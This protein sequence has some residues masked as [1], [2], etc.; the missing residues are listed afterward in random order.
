M[1]PAIDDFT[2]VFAEFME[3]GQNE[4]LADYCD[5]GTNLEFF[6]IY[7]NGYYRSTIDTLVSNYPAVL[8]LVGDDYFRSL[9]NHYVTEFPPC[10][11]SLVGY[12]HEFASFLAEHDVSQQLPYLSDIAR[13]DRAWL[14]VY[15][16]AENAPITVD[17]ISTLMGRGDDIAVQQLVLRA[18]TD[19]VSLDYVVTPVWQKLKETGRLNTAIEVIKKPEYVLVWRQHSEV[20][21]RPLPSVEFKFLSGLNTGLNLGEAAEIAVLDDADINLS[22]FFSNLITA[23]VLATPQNLVGEN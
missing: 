3:S 18:A 6:N 14:N 21:I 4:K 1:L 9:A 13:L 16:A 22:E 15:F 12:G 11:G 23:G 2:L 20:L 7:R 8:A 10:V 5:L 17:E 19:I